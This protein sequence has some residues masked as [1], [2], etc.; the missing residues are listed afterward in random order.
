L[1]AH[2]DWQLGVAAERLA[3]GSSTRSFACRP[4]AME[5]LDLLVSYYPWTLCKRKK[6]F[7]KKNMHE[8]MN[9]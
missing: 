4:W 7:K 2:L 1:R 5:T 6:K 9:E 3:T 8:R